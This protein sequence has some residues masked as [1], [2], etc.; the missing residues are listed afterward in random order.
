[1][2]PFTI[3]LY[4][5]CSK[6]NYFSW[7]QAVHYKIRGRVVVQLKS[8]DGQAVDWSVGESLEIF[9]TFSECSFYYRSIKV[10]LLTRSKITKIHDKRYAIT[11][12]LCTSTD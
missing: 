9:I 8:S 1:M 7:T 6:Q 3:A 12:T 10:V 2:Y 4:V 5:F 11:F